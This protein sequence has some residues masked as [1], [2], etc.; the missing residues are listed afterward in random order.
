MFRNISPVVGNLVIINILVF[1][2]LQLLN[3]PEQVEQYFILCKSS[4]VFPR[5]DFGGFFL[6]T[7]IVTY[8]FNHGGIF[9]IL[10][11]MVALTSI[12]TPIEHVFG[13]RKFLRFYLFCGIFGGI[14]VT[15]LDPS[16]YPVVGASGA[17]MGVVTA[18]AFYFPQQKMFIFPIP[19]PISARWMAIGIGV[20][21]LVFVILNYLN[22]NDG[23]QIS[24][25]GHL[26]GMVAA[27]VYFYAERYLPFLR[28]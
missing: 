22:I 15:L 24:H 27:L 3:V 11:N 21:S 17:I 13:A 23:G 14:L 16:P 2:V 26:A 5:G 6:P 25:F 10:F 12:G 1:A 28:K 8:F 18:F 9:H 19:F 20:L 7:Q 4:L